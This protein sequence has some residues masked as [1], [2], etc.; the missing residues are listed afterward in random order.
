MGVVSYVAD[1]ADQL[2]K[3]GHQITIVAVDVVGE[4]QDT[5]VYNVQLAR[6]RSNAWCGECWMGLPT[7]SHLGGP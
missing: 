5:A 7:G 6:Q 4:T 3:M 1:M 2:K